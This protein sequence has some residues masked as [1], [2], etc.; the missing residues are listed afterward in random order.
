M[1][2]KR[3]FEFF[4]KSLKVDNQNYCGVVGIA[5]CL[6]DSGNFNGALEVL[7]HLQGA[8]ITSAMMNMGHLYMDLGQPRHA[9]G[10]VS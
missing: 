1:F 3:A 10:Y 4:D 6:S 8:G 5:N 2:Y 9:I 7:E